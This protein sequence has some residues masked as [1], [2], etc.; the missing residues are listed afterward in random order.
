VAHAQGVRLVIRIADEE[1]IIDKSSE[2]EGT[3]IGDRVG[4]DGVVSLGHGSIQ[5][6]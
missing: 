1:Y 4:E 6:G 3:W 5:L 2:K